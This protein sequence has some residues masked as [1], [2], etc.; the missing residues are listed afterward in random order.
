MNSSTCNRAA[1][2]FIHLFFSHSRF[3]KKI[4]NSTG[5]SLV[6]RIYFA[7]AGGLFKKSHFEPDVSV[8]GRHEYALRLPLSLMIKVKIFHHKNWFLE[9][10]LSPVSL[11]SCWFEFIT[12]GRRNFLFK[13][14]HCHWFGRRY[15]LGY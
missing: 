12:W 8:F 1:E 4:I 15:V 14:Y 9:H 11:R 5:Q 6:Q 10:Q 3:K 2:A 7:D 13:L